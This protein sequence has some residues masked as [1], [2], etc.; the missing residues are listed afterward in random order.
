MSKAITGGQFSE[1]PMYDAELQ[2]AGNRNVN[3]GVRPVGNLGAID[4][5]PVKRFLEL[6]KASGWGVTHTPKSP[7]NLFGRVKHIGS[8]SIGSMFDQVVR[9]FDLNEDGSLK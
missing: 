5:E 3:A 7:T 9:E 2:R 4:G 8:R 6:M 1:L